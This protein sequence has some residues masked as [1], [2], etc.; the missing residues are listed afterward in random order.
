MWLILKNINVIIDLCKD[1]GVWSKYSL[2]LVLDLNMDFFFLLF[3]N[4]NGFIFVGSC[5]FDVLLWFFLILVCIL[6]EVWMRLLRLELNFWL[7]FF[8]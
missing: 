5:S 4:Y 3:Y 6:V 2:Y 7:L 1:I 8:F